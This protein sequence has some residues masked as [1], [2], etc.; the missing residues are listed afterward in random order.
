MLV[1]P[2]YACAY[3]RAAESTLTRKIKD[4]CFGIMIACA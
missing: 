1:S 3:E 4:P 2:A